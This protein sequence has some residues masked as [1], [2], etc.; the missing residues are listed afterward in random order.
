MS[1]FQQFVE[2]VMRIFPIRTSPRT[3]N[4]NVEHLVKEVTLTIH[5]DGKMEEEK[6]RVIVEETLVKAIKDSENAI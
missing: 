5:K 2:W 6:I 4:I 1:K 3:I